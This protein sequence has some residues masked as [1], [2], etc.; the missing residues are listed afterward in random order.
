[1]S[2]HYDIPVR[3]NQTYT[4]RIIDY[5]HEA[6]GVAKIDGYPIF[7]K[8]AMIGELIEFCVIATGKSFSR[9]VI[10]QI[11][12]KSTERVMPGDDPMIDSGAMDIGHMTYRAQLAFKTNQV[13]NTLSKIAG[14]DPKAVQ[15][16]I[17][18]DDPFE[19]R[20]KAQVPVRSDKN[21]RLYT[22]FFKKQQHTVVPLKRFQLHDAMIDT[23]IDGT[24]RI[25]ER[26]SLTGYDPVYHTGDIRHL[27][28]RRG[29]YTGQ[30]M[31]VIVTNRTDL[32]HQ[33]AI[34]SDIQQQ[35]P[36]V[37]SVIH[38]INTRKTNVI[39]GSDANVLYGTGHYC[40]QL[41][42]LTFQISHRS[43]L[44]VNTKQTEVMYR[45]ARDYATLEE[46]DIVVDAYSGIGTLT[47]YLAQQAAHVYGVEC[48]QDA[49][50]NARENA[51][52]NQIE[53]VS[54]VTRDAGE[55]IQAHV[56]H[57]NPI[58][59][60]VVD[61]PRKGLSQPFIQSVIQATPKRIVYISCNPSTLARDLKAFTQQDYT[62]KKVQPIDMFPQTHHVECVVLMSRK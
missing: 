24:L 30:L 4:A 23:V 47:L 52:C 34:S 62:I 42:D 33:A 58:D 11:I 35:F 9:G 53:N 27:V 15:D 43:F 49:T 6:L 25:L 12:E 39:L 31:I 60:L 38:N 44:Q 50:E 5:T 61:P 40:D 26:Y 19:Y 2:R 16:T 14:L 1:M 7:I 57:R 17:G 22:G 32:P 45:I 56:A 46:D 18:M 54:F 8:G 21:G 20:N 3:I 48:V 41:V 10:E 55:W 59:V 29:H 37:V 51:R 28:V 36:S 13:K